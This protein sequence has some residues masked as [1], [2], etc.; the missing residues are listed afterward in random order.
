[1]HILAVVVTVTHP[2]RR[3]LTSDCRHRR[4]PRRRA[5]LP[6][7]LR[8]TQPWSWHRLPPDCGVGPG[9]SSLS[10]VVQSRWQIL[11]WRTVEDETATCP[12]KELNA[13]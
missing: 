2:H 1:M 5:S 13:T 6:L 7:R 11:S 4:C 8:S 9:T 12:S 3:P 10:V